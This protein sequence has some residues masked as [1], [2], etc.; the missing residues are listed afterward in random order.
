MDNENKSSYASNSTYLHNKKITSYC[1]QQEPR[2]KSQKL[3]AKHPG[4]RCASLTEIL[5]VMLRYPDV[6]TG[7]RFFQSAQCH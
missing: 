2:K 4:G 1:I 7:L 5:H 3:N 6:Y